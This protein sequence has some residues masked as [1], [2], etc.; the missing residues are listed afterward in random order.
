M[1]HFEISPDSISYSCSNLLKLVNS[2][3]RQEVLNM[4]FLLLKLHE[5]VLWVS[6]G[7]FGEIY[8]PR[9]GI[10]VKNSLGS[11]NCQWVAIIIDILLLLLQ[12]RNKVVILLD[13]GQVHSF[14]VLNNLRD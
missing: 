12:H 6:V 7:L 10:F 5:R 11:C 4:G 8:C 9:C 2:S 14:L 3:P 13:F 1:R